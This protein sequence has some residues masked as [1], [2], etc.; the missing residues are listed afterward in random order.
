VVQKGLSKYVIREPKYV[1]E[2]GDVLLVAD[3]LLEKRKSAKVEESKKK[4]KP[5]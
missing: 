3:D 2:A 1:I 4:V 5:W